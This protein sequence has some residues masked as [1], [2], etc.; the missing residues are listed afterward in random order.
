MADLVE[1]DRLGNT[2]VDEANTRAETHEKRTAELEESIG[3]MANQHQLADVRHATT[4]MELHAAAQIKDGVIGGF[5]SV[6][7]AI[8]EAEARG[9]VVVDRESYDKAL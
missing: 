5:E 3:K 8:G 1:Y 6:A 4:I 2:L 9:L 7:A